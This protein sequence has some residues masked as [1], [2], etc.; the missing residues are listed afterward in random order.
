MDPITANGVTAALRHAE[1][2]C[3]LILKYGKRS[4]LPLGAGISYNSRI[5]Q[6]ADF[7]NSGVEDLVY[8]PQVRNRLGMGGAAGTSI[9]P[10]WVV[11]AFYARSK[12]NGLF[13]TMLLGFLM[14]FPRACQWILY[15]CCK[16]FSPS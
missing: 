9:S 6:L 11:N 10:A 4:K 8:Q 2:A 13:S 16:L 3:G 5:A 1:E 15:R 12:P 14:E 7:F